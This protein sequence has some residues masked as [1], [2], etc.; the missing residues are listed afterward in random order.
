MT[1]GQGV[2]GNQ[3]IADRAREIS[4]AAPGGSLERRAAGCVVVA[5]GTTT[6]L[7]A[8]R[9]AL[10]SVALDDVRQAAV[11]LLDRLTASTAQETVKQ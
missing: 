8:A 1:G 3:M 10:A 5:A 6:T 4:A 7:S 9:G 2:T 11:E